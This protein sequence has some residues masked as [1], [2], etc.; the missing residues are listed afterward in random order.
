M[1]VA[2]LPILSPCQWSSL[3]WPISIRS[4]LNSS[5]TSASVYG[6]PPN[7]L[8]IIY[9][10]ILLFLSHL[11]PLF[12]VV[13]SLAIESSRILLSFPLLK[14]APSSPRVSTTLPALS[15]IKFYLLGLIC[16]DW[17]TDDADDGIRW[18]RLPLR[19]LGVWF[20]SSMTAISSGGKSGSFCGTVCS[21]C[22]AIELP[23]CCW[24]GWNDIAFGSS[25]S[26]RSF[27][28]GAIL[29]LSDFYSWSMWPSLFCT[30][31][32][33]ASEDC[34]VELF[35]GVAILFLFFIPESIFYYCSALTDFYI[36]GNI[37][38]PPV[39]SSAILSSRM[40]YRSLSIFS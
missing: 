19:F 3:W 13:T 22:M 11:S 1:I 34:A 8:F 15:E 9:G 26:S 36:I 23:F 16:L 38:S 31:I 24:T 14:T 12:A 6:P 37:R 33:Y 17:F 21:W 27:I 29:E 5:V 30:D 28:I 20:V 2:S 35:D 40:P 39:P 7:H 25:S 10:G 18:R 32:A 4:Y